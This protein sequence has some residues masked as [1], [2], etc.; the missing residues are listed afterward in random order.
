MKQI[1]KSFLINLKTFKTLVFISILSFSF[2]VEAQVNW[3]N[4][5]DSYFKIEENQLVAYTLPN[6]D[7]KTVISKTQLTP[8][9]KSEPLEVVY[10][11]FSEDQRKI[12]LFT[13]TKKVWRLNT[14]GDYWVFDFETNTLMQLGKSLPSSSLLFAKFS[15]DG[16]TIAYVS[17]NNL[18]SEDYASGTIRPLTTDGTVTLI[19]GTFDWAYEEE[20]F[21][22]MG[23][24]GV[25]IVNILPIGRSMLAPSRSFIW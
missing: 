5:G 25:Q 21:V 8:A 6:Q 4:D 13:N 22:E 15:P 19:N 10:F 3:A 23:F 18:Y 24:V 2:N 9:G 17:D 7:V 20:F 16:K 11:T 1:K 14:K 12:L